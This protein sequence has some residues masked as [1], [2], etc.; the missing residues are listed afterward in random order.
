MPAPLEEFFE[1]Q[2]GH[3]DRLQVLMTNGDLLV[4]LVEVFQRDDARS[5]YQE[6]LEL[7]DV[8]AVDLDP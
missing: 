1:V 3:L 6:L 7:L 5:A 2:V 8:A 4:L